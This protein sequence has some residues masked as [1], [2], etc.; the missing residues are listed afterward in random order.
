MPGNL[1]EFRRPSAPQDA[2]A[3]LSRGDIATAAIV[4][5]PRAPAEPFRGIEAAVDLSHL[6]LAGIRDER[7]LVH[8]GGMTSLQ[9]VIDSP[10]TQTLAGGILARAALTSAGSAMRHVATVA[11]V[12]HQQPEPLF[13]ET[14]IGSPDV[15]MALLVLD[16]YVAITGPGDASRSMPLADFLAGG[17]GLE[18]GELLVEVQ[19]RQPSA[20]A[21]A[22]LERV[23]R[24]P[25]DQAIVAAAALVE[26]AESRV[27]RA[28]IAV[29]GTFP[30]PLRIATA[31][32]ALAGRRLDAEQ[33]QIAAQA[34]QA[35]PFESDFRASAD[36]RRAMSGVLVRR[37]LAQAWHS[38]TRG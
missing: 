30:H 33:L 27:R 20:H 18:K 1:R 35:A 7:G 14:R 4:F 8:I 10:I 15:L 13:E 25:R 11:G 2:S 12:V 21:G 29:G 22:S 38:A 26:A 37:A 31:E 9:D 34:A 16:A 19:F 23:A 36:Y 32:G 3:L 6:G 5:G 17:A 24:T 28:R